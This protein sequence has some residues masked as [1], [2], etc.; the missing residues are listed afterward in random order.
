[1]QYEIFW[2][3]KRLIQTDSAEEAAVLI[4][5]ELETLP[6]EAA[7]ILVPA[8][9]LKFKGTDECLMT[10]M[11]DRCPVG[12]Q[13]YMSDPCPFGGIC[14]MQRVNKEVG[15]VIAEMLFRATVSM[16]DDSNVILSLFHLIP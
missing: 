13:E 10:S 9:Y 5:E 6:P 8:G 14:M 11:K 7:G 1:M 4:R 16:R 2:A 15:Y 3:L 12:V